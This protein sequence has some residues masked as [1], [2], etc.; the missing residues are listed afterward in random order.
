VKIV[1]DINACSVRIDVRVNIF[2]VALSR[3]KL[4][5]L[6]VYN[7][8]SAKRFVCNHHFESLSLI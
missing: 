1:V 7:S 6:F 8:C 3:K 4:I 2:E 5:T